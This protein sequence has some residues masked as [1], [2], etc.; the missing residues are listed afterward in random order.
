[1]TEG[2]AGTAGGP[3][4]APKC[5]REAFVPDEVN[6]HSTYCPAPIERIISMYGK[7]RLLLLPISNED[8]EFGTFTPFCLI[9]KM[10]VTVPPPVCKICGE[11]V[12]A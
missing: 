8:A 3:T 2:I 12:N 9:Q 1:M 10:R 4:T 5:S 6:A 11:S 7:V